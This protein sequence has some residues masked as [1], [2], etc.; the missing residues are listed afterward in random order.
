M[1]GSCCQGG[2]RLSLLLA[3]CVYADMKKDCRDDHVIVVSTVKRPLVDPS[4]FR[5]GGCFPDSVTQ[6][7]AVFH[8]HFNDCGF[9]RLVS[10]EQ[11]LYSSHLTY[12]SSAEAKVAPFTGEP[13]VCEYKRPSTDHPSMYETEFETSGFAALGF[14][15]GLMN[16]DFSGPA[17]S[18]SFVLGSLIPI[19]ASVEQD[20]HQPLLLL[21]EE[22]AAST[23]PEIRPG[24][25]VHDIITNKGCLV[26]GIG[27]RSK[28]EERQNSSELKL[29]L[30]AFKFDDGEEVF[31]R[32]KLVAWNPDDMGNTKKACNYNEHH[33]WE[34]LDKVAY[35]DFCDCCG[36]AQLG[37][38]QVPL[39]GCV[40]KPKRPFLTY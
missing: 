2:V 24:T 26:D 30:Q 19:M 25:A 3:V 8:V 31:I 29:S 23:T 15:L 34:Q 9:T 37:R 13:V 27:T 1:M 4:L 28:F 18:S 36:T 32:C 6:R 21:L 17:E 10:G 40:E 22:C 35:R 38:H 16:S 7:E 12:D 5:L 14:H 11:L 20:S 33:G 39:Q